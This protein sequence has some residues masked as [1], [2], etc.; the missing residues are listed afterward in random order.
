VDAAEQSQAERRVSRVVLMTRQ[1]LAHHPARG[2][3]VGN[4]R[5]EVGVHGGSELGTGIRLTAYGG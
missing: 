5:E 3:V 2:D 4:T 1:H